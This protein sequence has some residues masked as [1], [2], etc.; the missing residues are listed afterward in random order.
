MISK[1]AAILSL[2]ASLLFSPWAASQGIPTYQVGLQSDG[3][4][5]TPANQIVAPASVRCKP[6]R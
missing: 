5:V 1:P 4:Y 3:S 6:F 2:M